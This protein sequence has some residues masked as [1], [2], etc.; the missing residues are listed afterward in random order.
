VLKVKRGRKRIT[1]ARYSTDQ[2]DGCI[3]TDIEA[4]TAWY[5]DGT[6]EVLPE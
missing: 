2:W 4:A 6:Y 5:D 1:L 3:E